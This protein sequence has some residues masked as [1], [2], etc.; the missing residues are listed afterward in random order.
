[1]P[2]PNWVSILRKHMNTDPKE[3]ESVKPVYGIK[4]RETSKEEISKLFEMV[5]A[6]SLG[7]AA[8]GRKRKI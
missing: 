6:T 3:Y 5:S 8:N 2:K 1:M 4:I 7:D